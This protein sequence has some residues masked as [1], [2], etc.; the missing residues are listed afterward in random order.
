MGSVKNI[1]N[2]VFFSL[3]LCATS[4]VSFAT[5]ENAEEQ[6]D[7][8]MRNHLSRRGGG[9]QTSSH[10]SP[11]FNILEDARSYDS[12]HGVAIAS[13]RQDALSMRSSINLWRKD[14]DCLDKVSVL[15]AQDLYGVTK[16]TPLTLSSIEVSRVRVGDFKAEDKASMLESLHNLTKC[17]SF[18]FTLSFKAPD[19]TLLPRFTNIVPI[20]KSLEFDPS[21]G[22]PQTI[23]HYREK[24]CWFL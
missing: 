4:S 18:D 8:Q 17:S 15:F 3:L 19:P 23:R 6:R 22:T 11:A 16:V 10:S 12:G 9:A 14:T 7:H 13:L 24:C 1:K 21:G 5:S 20:L 2:I